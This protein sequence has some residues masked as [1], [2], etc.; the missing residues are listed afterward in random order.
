MVSNHALT[1]KKEF[2]SKDTFYTQRS[3]Q[4]YQ[5]LKSPLDM[6]IPNKIKKNPELT[7]GQLVSDYNCDKTML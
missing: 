7:L 2:S 6:N 1:I 3:F 5:P 4:W